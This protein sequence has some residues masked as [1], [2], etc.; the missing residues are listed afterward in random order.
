MQKAA[1]NW[2][3]IRERLRLA[4]VP[5][6]AETQQLALRAV[7]DDIVEVFES[8][9]PTPWEA[10]FLLHAIW[11]LDDGY[12]AVAA[13]E[14]ASVLKPRDDQVSIGFD[15]PRPSA[16]VRRGVGVNSSAAV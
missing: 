3:P 15:L 8:Y 10:H 13:E 2:H 7:I 16:W 5:T 12:P 11:H 4:L 1:P 9:A 6:D 14:I